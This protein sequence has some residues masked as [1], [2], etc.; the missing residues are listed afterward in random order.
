MNI[1]R[2]K[3]FFKGF[4]VVSDFYNF[5]S[6]VF[7]G[8]IECYFNFFFELMFFLILFMMMLIGV[9]IWRKIL[10]GVWIIFDVKVI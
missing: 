7:N 10:K 1:K 5:I 6:F 8:F 3:V 2:E 4:I 9:K